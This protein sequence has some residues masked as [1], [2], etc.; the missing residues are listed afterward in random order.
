ML[1]STQMQFLTDLRL[2]RLCLRSHRRPPA[3]LLLGTTC[4][5][6]VPGSL[7]IEVTLNKT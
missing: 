7:P 4:Y 5:H 1:Q 3:S 2:A 6:L